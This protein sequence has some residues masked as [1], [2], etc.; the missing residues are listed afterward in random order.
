MVP[1]LNKIIF[2]LLV[3][4]L[5]ISPVELTPM[6][7][8]RVQIKTQVSRLHTIRTLQEQQLYRGTRLN[9]RLKPLQS[10]PKRHMQGAGAAA[11]QAGKTLWG[12]VVGAAAAL[13]AKLTS[14]KNQESKKKAEDD[15]NGGT[16]PS[17]A[18]LYGPDSAETNIIADTI[19]TTASIPFD[20]GF[21]TVNKSGKVDFHNP[22]AE[23]SPSERREIQKIINILKKLRLE[24]GNLGD[25]A[26]NAHVPDF[27]K[28]S[29]NTRVM[30]QVIILYQKIEGKSE[31]STTATTSVF[32]FTYDQAALDTIAAINARGEALVASCLFFDPKTK[33]IS[34]VEPKRSAETVE[35][36]RIAAEEEITGAVPKAPQRRDRLY[37][38]TETISTSE[39]REYELKRQLHWDT[40]RLLGETLRKPDVLKDGQFALDH[41]TN[42]SELCGTDNDKA[43]LFKAV[44][45]DNSYPHKFHGYYINEDLGN[46]FNWR[47]YIHRTY[48]LE[49]IKRALR[50]H[51][52]MRKEGSWQ[53]SVEVEE[54]EQLAE[55]LKQYHPN[56]IYERKELIKL[57]YKQPAISSEYTIFNVYQSGNEP[58]QPKDGQRA[59][60]NGIRILIKNPSNNVVSLDIAFG[61]EDGRLAIFERPG[62][63][64]YNYF[65]KYFGYF[66]DEN[67]QDLGAYTLW[68]FKRD[69]E[70]IAQRNQRIEELKKLLKE[71]HAKELKEHKEQEAKRKSYENGLYE[72]SPTALKPIPKPAPGHTSFNLPLPQFET[73]V[74]KLPKDG[75]KALDN[76]I[77]LSPMRKFG[78]ED[79]FL[80]DFRR[81][82]V[83]DPDK[84]HGYLIEDIDQLDDAAIQGLHRY[85]II[86]RYTKEVL[87]KAGE[88][89]W[90]VP[91]DGFGTLERLI[92]EDIA[93]Y[94]EER[95][96]YSQ[97]KAKTDGDSDH[98]SNNNTGGPKDPKDNK[99]KGKRISIAALWAKFLDT[100]KGPER[101]AEIKKKLKE[102]A[103]KYRWK[104]NEALSRKNNRTIYTDPKTKI[105]YSEDILHGTFEKFDSRGKHQGE[106]YIDLTP[107]ER[108]LD[109]SRGHDIQV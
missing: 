60:D 8:A 103:R 6:Q 1:Q 35:I 75:Q 76:A 74:S 95:R 100:L 9:A 108:S 31:S 2:S 96:K 73:G 80:V 39:E 109:R 104:K 68:G 34:Y 89:L 92:D 90:H 10:T 81:H 53:S 56:G 106:F 86:N 46:D 55:N 41:A 27:I 7:R 84:F 5:L 72:L 91:A 70:V 85:T 71:K 12:Y 63:H 65:P 21:I 32:S 13:A 26:T 37:Q 49:Q 69:P 62:T 98:N 54:C 15:S 48:H 94:V 99:D 57:S 58:Q 61:L 28:A 105:N 20:L 79:K 97:K 107:V 40:L 47:T 101:T 44:M 83:G 45:R 43:V 30:K 24:H 51:R 36:K 16:P 87:R 88:P 22:F 29:M 93:W 77:T 52:I 4:I 78:I 33:T 14:N 82:A 3:T 50:Y 59:L 42:L 66:I 25:I 19:A 67:I 38:T 17:D 102:M 23:W 18:I 64:S 11:A